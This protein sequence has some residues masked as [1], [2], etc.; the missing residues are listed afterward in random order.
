MR[1]LV[2]YESMYG[3]TAEVGEAMAAAL[4]P[5][6]A[7]DVMPASAVDAGGVG[8]YDLL[9]MGA[10][11]MA[12]S[13]PGPATRRAALQRD[14]PLGLSATDTGV[15]EL[16]RMLPPTERGW[17]AAF[18]T[19]LPGMA[20]LTGAPSR[21]IARRLQGHGYRMAAPPESFIVKGSPPR[22]LSGETV[23]AASWAAALA[24]RV[25]REALTHAAV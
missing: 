9:I 10:P 23:R 19:R 13:L 21:M 8:G 14:N 4:R 5:G 16:L 17:A 15:R 18:D 6:H 1:V 12:H 3:N 22:L 25:E 24:E 2:V 11:C 20:V 7:V